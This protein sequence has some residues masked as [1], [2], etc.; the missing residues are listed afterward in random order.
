VFYFCFKLVGVHIYKR[1]LNILSDFHLS[2]QPCRESC[3]EDYKV[4]TGNDRSSALFPK[5]K[6]PR[7]YAAATKNIQA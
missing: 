5:P 6:L 4:T 3:E 2:L 7:S 1:D